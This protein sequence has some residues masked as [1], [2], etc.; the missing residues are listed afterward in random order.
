ME[1]NQGSIDVQWMVSFSK[2]LIDRGGQPVLV[3]R[4]ELSQGRHPLTQKGMS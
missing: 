2:V 1:A 4:A 3:N